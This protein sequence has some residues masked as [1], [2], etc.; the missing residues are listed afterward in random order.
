MVRKEEQI[1]RFDP[2]TDRHV[3]CPNNE[4]VGATMTNERRRGSGL[5]SATVQNL[6]RQ[7]L[8]GQEIADMYG[9]TRARVSQIKRQTDGW[10]KTAFD[11]AEEYW[12]LRVPDRFHSCRPYKNLRSHGVYTVDPTSVNKESLKLLRGFYAHLA[13]FN[14][15]VVYDPDIPP[16]RRIATGGFAYRTREESDGELMIRPNDHTHGLD[17]ATMQ[18]FWRLPE[19]AH[20][21]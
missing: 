17:R 18:D 19:E 11:E 4:R 16:Q 6:L 12:P 5:T 20:W 8:S 21:P 3:P 2:V 14:L 15:I 7:G 9:L 13:D 1:P 10:T